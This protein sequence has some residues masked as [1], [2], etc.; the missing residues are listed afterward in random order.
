[1]KLQSDPTVKFA[2]GNPALRR[3]LNR[4][5]AVESPYNT[6]LVAGLPPG[7]ICL[8]QKSTIDA[9]LNAPE[10]DYI[11]MC[12]KSDFSGTH[13]FAANYQEHLRN[14]ERYRRELNKRGI[15]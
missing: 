14:A 13:D 15:K 2:V 10:H 3:I 11:Y 1:M 9:V 12:A 5:L 7:P 8:P 6:Y 4:H